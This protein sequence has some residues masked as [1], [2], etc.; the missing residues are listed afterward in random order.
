M[1]RSTHRLV[2]SAPH[3]LNTRV[4]LFKDLIEG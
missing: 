3:G 4:R 1:P 2:R